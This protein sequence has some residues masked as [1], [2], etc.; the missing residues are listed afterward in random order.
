MI[1]GADGQVV[2]LIAVPKFAET[3]EVVLVDTETL[4]VEVVK[5]GVFDPSLEA[6]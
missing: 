3:G 4:A 2:R 5:I 1:E 6:E